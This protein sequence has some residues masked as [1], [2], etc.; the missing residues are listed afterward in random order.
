MAERCGPCIGLA[1]AGDL[2]GAQAVRPLTDM[3]LDLDVQDTGQTL[4]RLWTRSVGYRGG[5]DGYLGGGCGPCGGVIEAGGPADAQGA[6]AAYQPGR[7]SERHSRANRAGAVVNMYATCNTVL[8]S[9]GAPRGAR[10]ARAAPT[11]YP[12]PHCMQACSVGGPLLVP[13]PIK[14]CGT[15]EV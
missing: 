5:G 2:A 6:A 8:P 9:Q 10:P 1:V 14:P 11:C 12:L 15:S 13:D 7:A 4:P 3:A